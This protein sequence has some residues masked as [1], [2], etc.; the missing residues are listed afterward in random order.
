MGIIQDPIEQTTAFTDVLLCIASIILAIV[1]MRAGHSKDQ[2]R[3]RLWSYIFFLLAFA[4]G[5]GAV[6]HGIEMS[7]TMNMI[8]WTPLYF[9]LGLT[10]AFFLVIV[11]LELW[12]PEKAKRFQPF[13]IGIGL[14]FFLITVL[15]PRT[16][17]LFIIYE[18]IAMV[19]AFIAFIY[20]CFK[21][22]DRFYKIITRVIIFGVMTL[23]TVGFGYKFYRDAVSGAPL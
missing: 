10:I 14:V 9:S 4:S 23:V 19:L 21:R 6:A 13:L 15:I 22:E 7:D 20:L 5:T 16:F 2:G 11:I 3:S 12:G 17:L 8:V 18:G 1:I